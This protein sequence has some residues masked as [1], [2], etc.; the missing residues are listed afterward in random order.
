MFKN[1]KYL[2]TSSLVVWLDA[3]RN[4]WNP[5]SPITLQQLK[6]VIITTITLVGDSEIASNI[7]LFSDTEKKIVKLS[8]NMY[9]KILLILKL[10]TVKQM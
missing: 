6:K 7:S 2:L 10:L 9:S 1:I 4:V 8:I 3:A 5:A